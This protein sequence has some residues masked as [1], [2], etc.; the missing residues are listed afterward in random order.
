MIFIYILGALALAR[1]II[2]LRDLHTGRYLRH[3]HEFNHGYSMAQGTYNSVTGKYELRAIL[4]NE[5]QQRRFT[6]HWYGAACWLADAEG[7][8][9][10][11]PW[12]EHYSNKFWAIV[13]TAIEHT[14]HAIGWLIENPWIVIGLVAAG[15]LIGG[16][17]A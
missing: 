2:L 7:K 14:L 5:I 3:H 16:L 17:L 13:G 1:I 10:P 15:V 12:G 11:R 8:K 6:K 9:W 4:H